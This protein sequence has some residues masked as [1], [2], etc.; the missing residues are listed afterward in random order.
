[1]KMFISITI[2]NYAFIIAYR[3]FP[4]S[5]FNLSLVVFFPS[6]AIFFKGNGSL[7]SLYLLSSFSSLPLLSV[8]H[9]YPSTLLSITLLLLFLF[10]STGE[11]LIFS[12]LSNCLIF[13]FSFFHNFHFYVTLY[14][15]FL[16]FS[17]FP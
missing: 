12:F 8:I 6:F 4:V 11:Y 9:P 17:I 3:I 14:I 16:S 1:M 2:V 13:F 10:Q 5:G 15:I 7:V